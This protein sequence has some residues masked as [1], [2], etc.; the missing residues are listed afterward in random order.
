MS[1]GVYVCDNLFTKDELELFKGIIDNGCDGKSFFEKGLFVNKKCK[2]G[3][4]AN[5]IGNRAIKNL[6][7]EEN[8]SVCDTMYYSII[9]EDQPFII[10]TDTGCCLDS[11]YTVLLYLNDTFTG[12]ETQF[13][14]DSFK[15]SIKIVPK[16]NRLLIFDIT[17]Y[18]SAKAVTSG[19]KRWIGTELVNV[20]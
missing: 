15:E 9:S 10:H 18:H 11:K 7:L 2:N 6:Q 12:G 8:L 16:A 17:L 4:I 20:L 1:G 5:L 19:V 3:E 14:T 13:Y